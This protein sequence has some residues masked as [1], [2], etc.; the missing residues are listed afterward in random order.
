LVIDRDV[1]LA[2][3]PPL[4]PISVHLKSLMLRCECSVTRRW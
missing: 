4:L 2:D 1:Y 3:P